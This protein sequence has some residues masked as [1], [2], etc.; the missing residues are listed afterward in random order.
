V[1]TTQVKNANVAGPSKA[2]VQVAQF[3]P[4]ASVLFTGGFDKTLRI[5]A[6]DGV[7]NPMAQSVFLPD[8][9]IN[10]GVFLRGGREIVLSGRRKFFYSYELESGTIRKVHQ[11]Q[12]RSEKSLEFMFASRDGSQLAFTGLNGEVVLVS[13]TTK[14]VIGSVKMNGSARAVAFGPDGKMHTAGG[15][16]KVYVWD[17]RN[18]KRC[19]H[20]FADDGAISCSALDVSADGQ[21]VAVGSDS[22]VVNVY[23]DKCYRSASPSPLKAIMNL[24][25]VVHKVEF[26]PDGQMLAIGSRVK[27]AAFRLFH[28]PSLTTFQNWPPAG[29]PLS[30]VNAFSFSANGGYLALGN[31]KGRAP[32]YRLNHY[33]RV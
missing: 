26:H 3:H 24:T 11:L 33:S 1:D 14:Q 29:G 12:G 19:V 5:F 7:D 13:P 32:M 9:P 25:T 21:Y 6:V 18:R 20:M 8:L 31:D 15:D 4:D 17:A 27:K 2:A 10:S 23:D 22:G 16:G 30:Y 28:L